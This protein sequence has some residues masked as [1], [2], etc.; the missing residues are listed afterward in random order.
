MKWTMNIFIVTY[1]KKSTLSNHKSNRLKIDP[2]LHQ[3]VPANMYI[4]KAN[5]KIALFHS[6]LRCLWDI[7]ERFN[8]APTSQPP[9]SQQAQTWTTY[10]EVLN[11]E[12]TNEPKC[13]ETYLLTCAPNDDSNQPAHPRYL[14]KVSLSA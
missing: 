2:I 13:E 10:V 9:G 14:I 12:Y 11:R 1:I 5:Y 8:L 3:T 4:S 6:L 7:S